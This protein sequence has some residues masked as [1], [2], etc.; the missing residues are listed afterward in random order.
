M[1]KSVYNIHMDERRLR[2]ALANLPVPE[3]HYR[4][5]VGSTNDLAQSLLEAGAADGTLV[6]ADAQNAGRGRLG[7]RWLTAPGSALAFSLAL[8][9]APGELEKL[10]FFAPLA[11]MAVCLALAEDYGL[12]AELKWPND[13]LIRRKK[14]CGVLVEATWQ[15]ATPAGVV[16]GIGVNVAPTSVPP[17]EALLFPASCVESELGRAVERVDLLA[18][19][20]RRVFALRPT[21]G[22]AAFVR[23]WEARLAFKGERVRVDLPG[24]AVAEGTLLG[25]ST[26]GGLRLLSAGAVDNQE[27]EIAAGDVRLRPVV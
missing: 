2:S 13:V 7:R 27:I 20:V 1:R 9:P 3:I 14:V 18:A 15:G 6:A 17:P 16:M 10:A 21:L 24:G 4:G 5:E 22:S 26:E 8:R 19:V 11:G 23:A 25:V 12:P